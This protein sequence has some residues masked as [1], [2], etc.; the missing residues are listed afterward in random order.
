MEQMSRKGHRHECA[1]F[2]CDDGWIGF[3]SRMRSSR[4]IK[5]ENIARISESIL[6]IIIKNYPI[7]KYQ[8]IQNISNA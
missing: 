8:V 5:A 3:L 1:P 4:V 6:P 7:C 2:L